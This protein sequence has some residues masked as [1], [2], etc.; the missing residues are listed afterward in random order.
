MEILPPAQKRLWP[1]LRPAA[2]LGLVLYGGTAVALRLGHRFSVDF[3][4]FTDK[5]LDKQA[6]RS[7]FS[8]IGG[9][10]TRI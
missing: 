10:I 2:R 6:L 9:G 1:E 4:F 5:P 3:D 7:A 8:F